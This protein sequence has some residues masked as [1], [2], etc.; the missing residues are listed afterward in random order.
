MPLPTRARWQSSPLGPPRDARRSARPAG[1]PSRT[2]GALE[3]TDPPRYAYVRSMWRARHGELRCCR[4]RCAG[5]ER[6]RRWRQLDRRSLVIRATAAV[7]A[8]GDSVRASSHDALELVVAVAP[9]D[10]E[11]SPHKFCTCV[12]LSIEARTTISDGEASPSGSAAEKRLRRAVHHR[13][14]IPATS[15]TFRRAS[16]AHPSSSGVCRSRDDQAAAVDQSP[17]FPIAIFLLAKTVA[18]L[19][20]MSNVGSSLVWARAI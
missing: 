10:P 3:R 7:D 1:V 8:G 14:P 2:A 11:G 13:A 19:D 6:S 4:V 12:P 18:T 17:S 15:V 16:R 5:V 9:A 20:R